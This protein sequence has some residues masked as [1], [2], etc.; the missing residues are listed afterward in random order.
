LYDY[1]FCTVFADNSD[2]DQLDVS[3][4]TASGVVY[5][6]IADFVISNFT[7]TF[8]CRASIGGFVSIDIDIDPF[9]PITIAWFVDCTGWTPTPAPS[10][11]TTAPVVPSG[12]WSAAGIF[13][14]TYVSLSPS[15]SEH[16]DS[17]FAV[18]PLFIIPPTCYSDHVD[19]SH[20]WF[21]RS[22]SA[23]VCS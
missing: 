2:F 14:F 5:P 8:N 15:Q 20:D 1:L 4:D 10:G 3:Y 11:P 7:V 19:I 13:F 12:G 16:H 21:E 9:Q 22:L 23:S 6:Q 17:L 18:G